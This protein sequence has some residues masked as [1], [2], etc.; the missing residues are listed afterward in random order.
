MHNYIRKGSH[1]IE[2]TRKA[3]YDPKQG[4]AEFSEA[5]LLNAT[6]YYDSKK[7]EYQKKLVI[8]PL[9]RSL[10]GWSCSLLN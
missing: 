7:H 4:M 8:L 9:I 5:L 1:K 2:T 10:P 3:F 6:L